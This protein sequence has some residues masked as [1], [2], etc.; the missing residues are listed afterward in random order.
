MAAESDGP[1]AIITYFKEN[2]SHG[3]TDATRRYVRGVG[4]GD[5]RGIGRRYVGGEYRETKHYLN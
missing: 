2:V 3:K 1:C 5:V 4:R